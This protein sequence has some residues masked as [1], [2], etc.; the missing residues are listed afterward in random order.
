M[1]GPY[2]SNVETLDVQ[3]SHID[4]L[5]PK[6]VP[7]LNPRSS[8]QVLGHCLKMFNFC[9]SC[10]VLREMIIKLNLTQKLLVSGHIKSIVKFSSPSA[11]LKMAC[12]NVFYHFWGKTMCRNFFSKKKYLLAA[13]HMDY[14]LISVMFVIM[15]VI[16]RMQMSSCIKS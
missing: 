14:C 16:I 1:S 3:S 8:E 7:C 2:L 10:L 9:L 6:E 5:W 4:C 15:F 11:P 12:P 13:W